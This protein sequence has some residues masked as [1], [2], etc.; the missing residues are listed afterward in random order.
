MSDTH[1]PAAGH[2]NKLGIRADA[3]GATAAFYAI[4]T[5]ASAGIYYYDATQNPM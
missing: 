5:A 1:A 4:A 2:G 3:T